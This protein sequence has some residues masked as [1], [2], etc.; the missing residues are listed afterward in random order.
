LIDNPFAVLTAV[1]APAILTNACSVLALGTG[2]RVARVVDRT[3]AIIS[4][5]STVAKGTEVHESRLAQIVRLRRRSRLLLTALRILYGS[6]G[7]FASCALISVIGAV[8]AFYGYAVAFRIA[9]FAAL[10]TGLS[11]VVALVSGCAVMVAETRLALLGADE[12]LED[13]LAGRP[14]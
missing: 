1:V 14:A 13:A 11:A 10:V 5:L 8:V 3:R 2:N 7:G 9:A 12:A 4:E 6:L